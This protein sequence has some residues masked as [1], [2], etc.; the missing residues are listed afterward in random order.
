[1]NYIEKCKPGCHPVGQ[2]VFHNPT[3]LPLFSLGEEI[4]IVLRQAIP[5]IRSEQCV[6]CLQ[7]IVEIVESNEHEDTG[8]SP[9]R[10]AVLRI[11]ITGTK[12]SKPGNDAR[13]AMWCFSVDAF[14]QTHKLGLKEFCV[15][16]ERGFMLTINGLLWDGQITDVKDIIC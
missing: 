2:F 6:E 9:D 4:L 8:F 14:G 13:I 3:G 5:P 16:N 15:G 11:P 7:Y 12:P 10:V 1:M